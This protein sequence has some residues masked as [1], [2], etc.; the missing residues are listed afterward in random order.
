MT[1]VAIDF[2]TSNTIVCTLDP[3]SQVPRTIALPSLSRLVDAP[4][5]DGGS[6]SDGSTL[7][8]DDALHVVPS[9][10]FVQSSE[11][12]LV[13]EVVRLQRL[14]FR[15]P[16]RLFQGFKRDLVAN[17]RP[18]AR[19]LDGTVYTPELV[20]TQFLQALWQEI[21]QQVTPSQVIFTV[22]VGSFERYLDWFQDAAQQLA[23][24]PTRLVDESTA[25]AL[26][27]AVHR[28]G[29]PVLVIDFGGGTLDLSLVR[30]VAVDRDRS[31][32]HADVIA[33][34]DAYV[35]GIDIDTWIAE[36]YLQRMAL[37]RQ[38]LGE[39][40]WQTLLDVAERLKIRLSSAPE[41]SESWF[42][43]ETFTAHEV[44]LTQHDLADILETRQLLEQLRRSLDEVLAIA[45]Y[46][47]ITKPE[48]EHVLLVG[49]TCQ[50]PA[51]QQLIVSYFGKQRVQLHKLFHAVAEGALALATIQD[52]QDE[53]RHGYAIRLWEPYARSYSYVPLFS[54]GMRYPCR[55]DDPLIL[56]V[57][58][59]GQREIHLDIGELADLA[60]AEVAFDSQGRMTSSHLATQTTF[61]S[62]N[63]QAHQ[64]CVAYLDPPGERGVDRIAVDFEINAQ[65]ILLATV[66][67]LQTGKVLLEA[68]TIAK[69]R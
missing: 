30:T 68:E 66:T 43:D 20:A 38:H 52:I 17:Y 24:P 63:L 35:G 36:D 31:V 26:G 7:S 37:S 32:L 41:A 29:L 39:L 22:P 8:H 27:Y 5:V 59:E 42:D 23:M 46:K 45:L 21:C 10:V 34:S 55:R 28:P 16:D 40:G 18:P 49:G 9:L 57:A 64:T 60:Q 67:D 54:K 2:G 61:R 14:G 3:I 56:Q 58:T 44:R 25:A 62:L 13:G 51:I 11:R 33:K 53:L 47:G 4:L 48:I 69:L 50:I 65:R 6:S 15:Q 12:V 19:Q 1:I